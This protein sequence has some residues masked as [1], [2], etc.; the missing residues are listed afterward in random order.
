MV[1]LRF[2]SAGAAAFSRLTR[3]VAHHGAAQHAMQH[4]ALVLDDRILSVPFIDYKVAPQGIDG[5]RGGQVSGNLT[6]RDTQI[7]AAILSTGPLD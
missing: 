6:E 4:I 3:D 5:A 2:T 1:R 7:L